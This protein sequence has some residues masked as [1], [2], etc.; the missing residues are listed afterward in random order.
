M[1]LL[2]YDQS[3]KVFKYILNWTLPYLT[4]WIYIKNLICLNNLYYLSD[5]N[6]KKII[7]INEFKKFIND[8]N[9][10][11]NNYLLLFLQKLFIIS[12]ISKYNNTKDEINYNINELSIEQLFSLLDMDNIYQ[13]LSKNNNNEIIFLDLIEK[14]PKKLPKDN[15][16]KN[17]IIVDYYKIFNIMIKNLQNQKQEKS[18]ISSNLLIQF[19]PHKFEFIQLNNNIFDL[20]E[21]YLYKKCYFCGNYAKYFYICLICGKKICKTKKCNLA[22]RHIDEC[23]QGIGI[24]INIYNMKLTI[25][26]NNDE[27]DDESDD[28]EE[29]VKEL[30]SLYVDESG[31][32]PNSYEVGNE[33]NLSK[34]KIK[35]ALRDYVS[36][37]IH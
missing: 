27:D 3:I 5:D 1:I 37:D 15:Y 34:E 16:S 32:G 10:Q 35:M 19:I 7:N 2:D 29:Q 21:N 18:L 17:N 28:E 25:M 11:M 14:L 13:S 26:K 9:K 24:L 6:S 8:N 20:I 4:F 33:Y 30:Y 31:V 22:D 36:N 23:T 12:L